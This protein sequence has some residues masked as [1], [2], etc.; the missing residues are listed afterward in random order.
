LITNKSY[1]DA[2]FSRNLGLQLEVNEC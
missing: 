2:L 1:L